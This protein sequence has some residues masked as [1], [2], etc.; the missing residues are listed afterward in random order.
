MNS[1][2]LKAYSTAPADP[3]ADGAR[4]LGLWRQGL[5]HRNLP[6]EKLEWY[7]RRNPAGTP[8][9]T[10]LLHG[11]AREPVGVA[12]AARRRMRLGERA[13]TAGAMID[14]V[15]AP[16]HRTLFPAMLLQK[17]VCREALQSHDLLFG[18]PNPSSVAAVKRVGYRFVG[19]LVRRVRVLRARSYL[20]RFLPSWAGRAAGAAIDGARLAS[21]AVA[22][23]ASPGFCSE[24]LEAP[25]AR[26]DDLWSRAAPRQSLVGVRDRDFLAWR[27]ADC[28]LHAYRFFA[29][30]SRADGRLA[31]YAVCE[32]QQHALHVRDFLAD[33]A[34]PGAW[35][36]LWAELSREAY[37]QGLASL[38]VEFLGAD[39]LQ[40]G[41]AAAGLL[42][43]GVQPVYAVLP[44]ALAGLREARHWYLTD[45]DEDV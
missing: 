19:N 30:V 38:S 27:F 39:S 25:D 21:I 32:T 12:A 5:S 11:P 35:R 8:L 34:R 37:A 4:I 41:L 17:A 44:P 9:V 22:R 29:V 18:M 33:P 40:R 36:R 20:S 15:V 42:A 28:P 16:A 7:Y 24:W 23:L 43:R 13:L 2:A 14:F 1:G 31:A 3:V 6:E 26:F 45:A 10:F